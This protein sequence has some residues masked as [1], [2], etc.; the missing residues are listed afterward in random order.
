MKVLLF[1]IFGIGSI[2]VQAQN[3][4]KGKITDASKNPL[5]GA[6]IVIY[7]TNLGA[8]SDE[9]GLFEISNVMSGQ[10]KIR[11]SYVG[12]ESIILGIDSEDQ[13]IINIQL[14]ESLT[15]TN[16]VTVYATRA[17]DKTPTTYTNI[18]SEKIAETI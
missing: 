7:G 2:L 17:N 8:I 16:E 13:S 11:I 3:L 4:I 18:E 12:Y 5:F 14:E 9:M 1:A 15:F 6:S 10:M